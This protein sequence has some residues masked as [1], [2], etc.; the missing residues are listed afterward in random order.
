MNIEKGLWF[1]H[2]HFIYGLKADESSK[3]SIFDDISKAIIEGSGYD[4]SSD[5]FWLH[6]DWDSLQ[7]YWGGNQNDPKS[8]VIG[9]NL[10]HWESFIK[11]GVFNEE[12]FNEALEKTKEHWEDFGQLGVVQ[13]FLN[14]T[15]EPEL[16]IVT[17]RYFL[18]KKE[19]EEKYAEFPNLYTNYKDYLEA[20]CWDLRE[21]R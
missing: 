21:V 16:H 2:T 19:I 7:D 12:L 8:L 18:S 10:E 14:S 9:T 4:E 17:S 5:M 20:D 3:Q 11:D 15:K 1:E 6:H 13:S